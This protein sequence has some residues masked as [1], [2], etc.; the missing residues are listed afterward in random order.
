MNETRSV[1]RHDRSTTR[2][3]LFPAAVGAV[4]AGVATAVWVSAGDGCAAAAGTDCVGTALLLPVVGIPVGVLVTW[5][6]LAW[7]VGAWRAPTITLAGGAVTAYGLVL[8]RAGDSPWVA[9]VIGGSAFAGVAVACL[10]GLARPVRWAVAVL[11]ALV[12]VAGI[13]AG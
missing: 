13:A 4:A 9:A 5:A 11:L 7:G 6:V 10:P 8:S 2:L 1:R 12:C 3:V